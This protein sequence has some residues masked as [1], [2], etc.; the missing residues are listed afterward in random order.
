MPACYRRV[1][2]DPCGEAAAANPQVFGVP[3]GRLYKITKQRQMTRRHRSLIARIWLTKLAIPNSAFLNHSSDALMVGH[4]MS[5]LTRER[6]SLTFRREIL[7]V[8]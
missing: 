8:S 7:L 3:A 6:Y 2:F 5:G 4:H 1:V